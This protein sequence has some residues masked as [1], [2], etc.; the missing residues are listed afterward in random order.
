MHFRITCDAN[1]ESGVGE[2]VGEL[3]GPTEN[4]FASLDYRSGLSVLGVV[5]MCRDP[6]L[7]FKRRIRFSKKDQILYMDVM[8][9]LP[10]M[11][12][13]THDG[14]RRVIMSKLEREIPKILNKYDFA[15]FD[16]TRFET[17]LCDW[18]ATSAVSPIDEANGPIAMQL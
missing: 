6:A 5:L 8:L 11:I 1:Q 9:D 15:D 17:D 14:R 13:L 10:E 3:S 18:F 7:N 16:R 12:A 2:I 4:H